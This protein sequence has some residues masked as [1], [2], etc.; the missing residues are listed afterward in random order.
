[1]ALR[2][3]ARIVSPPVGL[4]PLLVAA[5]ILAAAA[6]F[7]LT[8]A[9]GF[10]DVGVAQRLG[11]VVPLDARFLAEDGS[12]VTLRQM[13]TAPTILALVYYRCPNACDYLLTGLASTL[14]PLDA[15]PGRDFNVVTISIDPRETGADAR[16]ARRIGLESI[17][18]PFPEQSWRFLT[19]D[20]SQIHSVAESIGFHYVQNR[21]GFDH[22]VAIVILSPDG[23]V[24]RY[25][26]GAEFLPADLKLSL[27]EAQKGTIGPTIARL[28]R[29]CFRVDPKSHTFVFRTMQVIATVTLLTAAAFVAFL[30][31][32]GR[33]RKRRLDER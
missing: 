10:T 3:D 26:M 17:G 24:V 21:D 27:L 2:H 32:T 19:G 25:M 31:V 13:I 7:G 20:E 28:A 23:K 22:P 1:M 4:R 6:V 8:S 15:V 30:L 5:G 18:K 11:A 14:G 33:K 16:K 9:A 29:I 12:P